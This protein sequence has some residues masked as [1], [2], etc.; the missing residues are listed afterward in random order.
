M[1]QLTSLMA[2]RSAPPRLYLHTRNGV[3]E[4]ASGH[5]RRYWVVARELCRFF[6]IPL[7][8]DAAVKRQL[9]ALGLQIKRLSPFAET[10][11]HFHFSPDFVS[12]W[13]WDQGAVQEA[14][15]SIGADIGRLRILPETALMPGAT[16]GVRLVVTSNGIEGQSWSQASLAASR[17]WPALPDSRSWV[18]FQRGASVPPDRI[19]ASLPQ[20]QRL[21]WLNRPWTRA[22]ASASHGLARIDLRLAAAGL[23]VAILI[24]YG[25]FG[26]EWLRLAREVHMASSQSAARLG[27]LEPELQTRT[28][29]LANAAAIES[30]R[31]LDRFPSQLALMARVAEILPRNT[32][33]FAEWTFEH[34]KLQVAV[35]ADHRLDAVFFVRSLE[36]IP[37]LTGVAAEPLG[38]GNALRIRL[39]VEPR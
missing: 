27:A 2:W 12:L 29:A 18:L 13:L 19:A 36:K 15:A 7:L 4:P 16:E 10:G 11:S 9:D 14:A 5:G 25:Y 23:G 17:W 35:A 8:P 39:T 22:P 26:G 33:H 3:Q 31:K 6:Q 38:N 28:T 30:L 21:D 24:G 1:A 32:A 34:G 37:G 20:P